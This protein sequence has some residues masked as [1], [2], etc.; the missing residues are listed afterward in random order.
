MFNR[1][2]IPE[3]LL[4][5]AFFATLNSFGESGSSIPSLFRY[6]DEA[7][8]ELSRINTS[9]TV[10][11]DIASLSDPESPPLK[12]TLPN[13]LQ[14]DVIP[15]S[16]EWHG[17]SSFKWTGSLVGLNGQILN[18][19]F[20]VR[21]EMVAGI[22]FGEEMEFQLVPLSKAYHLL[23]QV[24]PGSYSECGGSI[25]AETLDEFFLFPT[26]EQHL[27][28]PLYEADGNTVI[29]VLLVYTAEARVTAGGTEQIEL[30]LQNA[31]DFANQ[32]YLNS[33]VDQEVKLVA[34]A[35]NGY[36][37]S[38]KTS[39]EMLDEIRI[40]PAFHALRDDYGADLVG[41]VTSTLE[42]NVAGIAFLMTNQGL[43]SLFAP[44]AYS[45]SRLSNL[46]WTLTHEMGHNM[47][48]NHEPE[49]AGLDPENAAYPYAYGHKLEGLF[50]TIMSYS[51]TQVWC[52][53][54]Q[55]FSNPSLSYAGEATGIESERENWRVLNDTASIVSDFRNMPNCGPLTSP[56][57]LEY[58]AASEAGEFRIRW[59]P[60]EPNA[61]KYTL[62]RSTSSSFTGASTIYSG[63]PDFFDEGELDPNSYYYRVRAENCY[64]ASDWT[65]GSA[66]VVGSTS[67]LGGVEFSTSLAGTQA[68]QGE[69]FLLVAEATSGSS[70]SFEFFSS[71]TP[72]KPVSPF[73]ITNENNCLSSCDA[74]AEF[75]APLENTTL[76]F[77]LDVSSDGDIQHRSLSVLVD[78]GANPPPPDP[79]PDHLFFPYALNMESPFPDNSYAGVALFNPNSV[80]TDV[81][82]TGYDQAGE[83]LETVLLSKLENH[84][85]IAPMGQTALIPTEIFSHPDVAS[86]IASGLPNPVKLFFML[87]DYDLSS[88]DGVSG[89][90]PES[91]T[92]YFPLAR[93]NSEEAVALFLFNSTPAAVTATFQL[94]S[95]AGV[96]IGE[97]QR[98]I[99]ALGTVTETLV[100]LFGAEEIDGYAKVEANGKV[101]GFELYSQG[102]GLSALAAQHSAE[103]A[104]LIAPHYFATAGGDTELRL[105]NLGQKYVNVV[106]KGY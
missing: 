54:I 102:K 35:E 20:T 18:A 9:G 4:A 11:V 82:F 69:T 12:A 98:S 60:V 34:T 2:R 23:V 96:L 19:I 22:I 74:T 30:I 24:D 77:W 106:V 53:R 78:S 94:Y 91:D 1:Y 100:Q 26:T 80:S 51:C 76:Y 87:G 55:Y 3:Y 27:D 29:D 99:P 64:G 68:G 14:Y 88:L 70:V 79:G 95:K 16:V 62:Q 36:I 75:T 92:L 10:T 97:A 46:H 32:A 67:G 83:Q 86:V 42:G 17:E 8:S 104:R 21:K 5:L 89:P 43:G 63:S 44:Y 85:L 7:P 48:L 39:V 58:P 50:R 93:S 52:P 15:S 41:L 61:A 6:L 81:Q 33:D 40:S 47:G 56:E 13:G 38:G 101:K 84:N 72:N 25:P 59:D 45:V 31:I 65:A 57:H 28:Q 71:G 103:R 90:L 73:D 37:E 105:Q 49:S 66:V